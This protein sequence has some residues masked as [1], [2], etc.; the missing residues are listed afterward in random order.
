ML[1]ESICKAMKNQI[2]HITMQE[3]DL[4][5]VDYFIR[6]CGFNRE[7]E[8]YE[9]LL[10]KGM[11]IKERIKDKVRIQAI[12]TSFDPDILSG[13]T[14]R[15]SDVTFV[16]NAFE[17]IEPESIREIY[18]YIITAGVYELDGSDPILEQLYA[19]I[20]GTAYVDAGLEILK[21]KLIENVIGTQDSVTPVTE[22][23]AP[24]YMESFGPGFYGMDVDQVGN[25]FQLLDG[26]QIGVSV[27]NNCLMVPLK[28]CSG[29]M[30][31]VGDQSKLPAADCKSCRA[32][33]KGCEFC[34]AVVKK[35]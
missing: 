9:K 15:M 13:N 25:F 29:F 20:W 6:I 26:S 24:I 23:P 27:R 8:K 31:A 33:H 7:G 3:A 12:V 17:Q 35:K 18:A 1:A 5:A 19:D 30:V 34:Q 4:Y 22:N 32:D 11:E 14:A 2:I 16:C 28:S 10:K 21:Q